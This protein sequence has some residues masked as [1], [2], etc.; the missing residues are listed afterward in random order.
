VP[1]EQAL[2]VRGDLICSEYSSDACSDVGTPGF[3]PGKTLSSDRSSMALL[4]AGV[5]NLQDRGGQIAV[6]DGSVLECVMACRDIVDE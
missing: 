1:R 5:S 6:S 2:A 3:D 4:E